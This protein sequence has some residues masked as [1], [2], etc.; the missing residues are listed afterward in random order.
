M[1]KF[2]N[3]FEYLDE[4]GEV[5]D[6]L[7]DILDATSTMIY[8]SSGTGKSRL[9]LDLVVHGLEGRAWAG[10]EWSTK[11]ERVAILATDGGGQRNTVELIRSAIKADVL[12]RETAARIVCS[13]VTV[14][15]LS[16]ATTA[17]L[18]TGPSLLVVDTSSSAVGDDINSN[19]EAAKFRVAVLDPAER[20][21]VPVLLLH[22]TGKGDGFGGRARTPIGSQAWMANCRNRMFVY[23]T[24]GGRLVA[25][26]MP[27]YA[28]EFDFYLDDAGPLGTYAAEQPNKETRERDRLDTDSASIAIAEWAVENVS[29]S[30]MS[31][32]SRMISKQ[33]PFLKASTVR[34]YLKNR[35]KFARF[36]DIDGVVWSLKGDQV[37]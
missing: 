25:E 22:H 8:A 11:L 3:C 20:R 7:P 12:S 9:M 26:M 4:H 35:T 27:R 10:R 28:A 21:R 2:V 31:E 33:F 37:A 19:A 13:Q 30:N 1:I 6:P 15:E 36:L 24:G 23:R 18:E 5:L 32:A 29:T 34:D 17:A 14:A 16:E